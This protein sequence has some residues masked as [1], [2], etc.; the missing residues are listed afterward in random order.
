MNADQA[1]ELLITLA[2]ISFG[3]F[4]L[5]LLLTTMNDLGGDDDE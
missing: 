4:V 1:A 2:V 5:D 3:F